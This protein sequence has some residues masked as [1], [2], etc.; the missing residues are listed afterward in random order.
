MDGQTKLRSSSAAK[1]AY[2]IL[3]YVV[4][5]FFAILAI[6]PFVFMFCS[7]TWD[8][9]NIQT[10][11][12][13]WPNFKN[14]IGQ[15]KANYNTLAQRSTFKFAVGFK[16]SMLISGCSTALTVYFSALTAYGLKCYEFKG[17][18]T[19]FAIIVGVMMVP[20]AVN[21]TGFYRLMNSMGLLGSKLTL[22]IPAIAAP[23]TVFFIKQ[24]LDSSFSI[25]I[26]EAARIDGAGEFYTFNRISLPIMIPAIAT[27]AIFSFLGSWNNFFAPSILL[28]KAENKTLPLMV[29]ELYG[30]RF[31]DYGAIYFGLSASVLPVVIV[32]CFLQRYIISGVAAGGVKE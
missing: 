28:N 11:I 9:G 32:Y 30:D 8:S 31:T 20:T 23:N 26:V 19:V 4:V 16:N 1:R 14:L 10:S 12:K 3:V 22:I 21:I 7:A 18:K 25:D 27:Q 24:Y 2:C 6:I 17:R 29:A 15:T 13:L 5:A